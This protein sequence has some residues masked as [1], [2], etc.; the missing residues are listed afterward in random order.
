M[1]WKC[2]G[3]KKYDAARKNQVKLK[4]LLEL[5]YNVAQ[6]PEYN[7]AIVAKG[8]T[9]A[10]IDQLDLISQ[11]LEATNVEQETAKGDRITSAQL[12]VVKYNTMYNYMQEISKASKIVF[13]DDYAKQQQYLLYNESSSPTELAV[14]EGTLAASQAQVL[15]AIPANAKDVR[16]GV[17]NTDIVEF[18]FTING[19]DFVGNTTTVSGIGSTTPAITYFGAI[20]A[21]TQFMARN[22]NT[23]NSAQYK[24]TFL[25]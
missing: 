23:A 21:A 25:G 17:L 14:Y 9:Q 16:L 2:F 10:E 20:S 15:G 4:E 12:R 24:V 13:A 3:K 7:P 5:A 1:C 8:F 22:Q 11:T 19:N 6:K 18:G